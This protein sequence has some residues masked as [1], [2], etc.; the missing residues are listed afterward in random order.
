M[1]FTR[2]VG[3]AEYTTQGALGVAGQ[4]T[5]KRKY[6]LSDLIVFQERAYAKLDNILMQEMRMIDVDDPEPKVLTMQEAPLKFD[7]KSDDTDTNYE[8]D[9]LRLSDTQ[10]VFLQAGDILNVPDLFCDTDGANYTTTKYG[11][12]YL[13]ETIVVESV[14]LSGAASGIANVI[15]KRGNGHSTAAAGAGTV[16]T[17]LSEYKLIH[18]GNAL[19]DG[20]NAAV[21]V[22]F[23]PSSE[24]NFCQFRSKTWSQTE[25]ENRINVY[26]KM[27]M[28]KLAEMKRREFF[29]E[30]EGG[31]F[32]GRKSKHT[33]SSNRLQWK[34][35]GMLEFVPDAT[36]ALDGETRLID[37]GGAFD[38]QTMREKTEVIYRYGNSMNVKHWFNGGKFFTVLYNALESFLTVNDEFSNRYGWKVFELE[39]GHGVGML[40]RHPL[41]TDQSTASNEYS[42]DAFIVDLEYIWQMNYIPVQTKSNIQDNDEHAQKDEIYCQ[43][44]L[45]RTFPSAHAVVYGITG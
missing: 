45:H 42:M 28:E 35:G 12:G 18:M 32:F 30:R 15:V 21:P 36:S 1:A 9:T 37:F 43:K 17:I 13:P 26:G 19:S 11:S 24:Q 23:E 16:T 29:R 39:L 10:A 41:L 3:N 33:I 4:F 40:H 14:S 7:I 2:T 27:T 20:G 8:G 25:V 34:E 38:I 44:G 31:N 5:D 6:S 22:H